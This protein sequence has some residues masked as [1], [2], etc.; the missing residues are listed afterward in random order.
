MAVSRIPAPLFLL[1]SCKRTASV[2][3]VRIGTA[4]DLNAKWFAV[5]GTHLTN[6]WLRNPKFLLGL[7]LYTTGF[8]LTVYHDYILRNLRQPGGPRYVIPHGGLFEYV[9]CAQYLTEIWAFLGFALLSWGP[10][11]LFILAVSLCN[12]VPRAVQTT[13]WYEREFG[14]EWP[15]ERYHLIPFVF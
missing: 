9:T 12:L 15:Q 3:V 13:H 7:L 6:R 10:N 11:G 1:S 8:A 4:A 5:H 14:E 2:T